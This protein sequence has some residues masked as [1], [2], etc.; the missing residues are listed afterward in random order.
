MERKRNE[1]KGVKTSLLCM[2]FSLCTLDGKDDLFRLFVKV[3]ISDHYYHLLPRL[4][5]PLVRTVER[6]SSASVSPS[7]A[8]SSSWNVSSRCPT[9]SASASSAA[10]RSSGRSVGGGDSGPVGALRKAFDL[11][12]LEEALVKCLRRVDAVRV[13]ELDVGEPFGMAGKFVAEDG[14]TFDGSASVEVS[15]QLLRRRCVIHVSDVNGSIVR[16]H[17]LLDGGEPR[18]PR[19]LGGG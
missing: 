2:N 10:A 1:C 9:E 8:A 6:S 16:L 11:P 7:E 3:K 12:S 15:F 17:L 4:L 5:L 19:S 14:D 18:R 13:G